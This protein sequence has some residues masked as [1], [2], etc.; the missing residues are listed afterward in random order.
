MTPTRRTFG[1]LGIAAGVCVLAAPFVARLVAQEAPNR[2]PFTIVAKDFRFTPDRIEVSQN[3]LV[4]ITIQS[5][6]V[7]Y[8]FTIEEFRIAKRVPAGQSVTVEI[9]VD[10]TGTFP[11]Y[12]NMTSDP[13]HKDM[14]GQL[15]V[16]PR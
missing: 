13:R 4:K 8:G 9:R 12:S 10:R 1:L 5:E 6:D 15:I 16:R 14:Q 7:A 2:P 3:D 11:F